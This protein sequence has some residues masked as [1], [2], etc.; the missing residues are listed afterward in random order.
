MNV[1]SYDV[2]GDNAM[3]IRVEE[4]VMTAGFVATLLMALSLFLGLSAEVQSLVDAVILA[5]AGVYSAW[6]LEARSALPLLTGLAKAVLALVAGL[7]LHVPANV[8]AGAFAV[9]AVLGSLYVQSQVVAKNKDDR[10]VTAD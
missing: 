3:G 4:P 10:M 8:Q 9:L 1:W 5:G 2:R 7:G 6:R